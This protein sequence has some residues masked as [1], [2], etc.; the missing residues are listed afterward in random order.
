[1]A[2]PSARHALDRTPL[3]IAD[4][5]L[6]ITHVNE[7]HQDEL[8]MFIKAFT[9]APLD[10]NSITSIIELY[11]KGMLLEVTAPQ[12]T[13]S[14]LNLTQQ[15]FINFASTIDDA[16]S[17]H[18]QYIALLQ[19]VA[20]KLGKRTIKLREQFFTVLDGY[21]ASPNM[22]RVLVKAPDHTPLDQA[23]YAYLLE[24]N[25]ELCLADDSN[26]QNKA[27]SVQRY[28][29]LRKAWQDTKSDAIHA[30]IDVYIHGSTP[31]GDWAR[32]LDIGMPINSVRE[33]PE[34][35]DHLHDGQSLLICD[36]TSFPT[37]AN[38]LE[39]WQNPI[40]PL[41]IAISNDA[42]DIC[43]LRDLTLSAALANEARFKQDNLLSITNEAT[44]ALTEQ[45]MTCLQTRLSTSPIRIDK[46]WGAF[47]AA[48]VKSL[49]PQLKSMLGLSRQDMM[50][51]VYWR[52][53]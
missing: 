25:S 2:H 18:E 37:V 8:A 13:Q 45:I 32:S 29:T 39:N 47:E 10:D 35:L 43:Y 42:K 41:V 11:S 19:A 17:L 48:D 51:K 5:T 12:Y 52:A 31:G 26:R 36:E 14:A 50:I 20:T 23:G 53:Q 27:Q 46:V 44:V 28:Y 34:K 7:E 38:L 22:Y 9:K 1:M 3:D 21:Y 6:F 16:T 30:W 4:K 33:Y 40:P 24:L 49:R 15:Y